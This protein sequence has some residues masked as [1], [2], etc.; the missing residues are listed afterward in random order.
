MLFGCEF[1]YNFVCKDDDVATFG[2]DVGA[3]E[4]VDAA[5]P[6]QNERT[7]RKSAREAK[8]MPVFKMF[9]N[10]NFERLRM[11]YA[12]CHPCNPGRL[13]VWLGQKQHNPSDEDSLRAGC[14]LCENVYGENKKSSGV[15]QQ[16]K[17]MPAKD[18]DLQ[19]HHE[20]KKHQR[21]LRN[22]YHSQLDMVDVSRR[23]LATKDD[24]KPAKGLP[25]CKDIAAVWKAVVLKHS[26]TPSDFARDKAFDEYVESG[27]GAVTPSKETKNKKLGKWK[28]RFQKLLFCMA[29]VVRE[30][31]RRS[32]KN[33]P[34]VKWTMTGDGKVPCECCL[35]RSVNDRLQRKSGLL[36]I[37]SDDFKGLAG[38]DTQKSMKYSLKLASLLHEMVK[39]FCTRGFSS[40]AN[41]VR[42]GTFDA[43]LCAGML[44]TLRFSFWDGAPAVQAAAVAFAGQYCN[45]FAWNERDFAHEVR[46]AMQLS[47]HSEDISKFEQEVITKKNSLVKDIQ[48]GVT[49]TRASYIEAQEA[50]IEKDGCQ[51]GNLTTVISH[52][53]YAPQRWETKTLV[54][55]HWV[56][57]L[58]AWFLTC[59]SQCGKASCKEIKI[60]RA[61]TMKL[62]TRYYY[63]LGGML[64]DYYAVSQVLVKFGDKRWQDPSVLSRHQRRWSSKV[65]G[66]YLKSEVLST[67]DSAKNLY[68]QIVLRQLEQ[69][70]FCISQGQ[71]AAIHVLGGDVPPTNTE[72]LTDALATMSVATSVAIAAV[73]ELLNPDY[74]QTWWECMDLQQWSKIKDDT[75][76]VALDTRNAA[77]EESEKLLRCREKLG[78]QLSWP[79]FE[80][81]FVSLVKKALTIFRSHSKPEAERPDDW[82]WTS[83]ADA[84]VPA[85]LKKS[86]LTVMLEP[87]KDL[88]LACR[89]TTDNERALFQVARSWKL[90]GATVHTESIRDVLTVYLGA[91]QSLDKLVRIVDGVMMPLE[92]AA[93]TIAFWEELF[94]YTYT[95]RKHKGTPRPSKVRTKKD[96]KSLQFRGVQAAFRRHCRKGRGNDSTVV[97]KRIRSLRTSIDAC[98]LKWTAKQCKFIENMKKKREPRYIDQEARAA[99]RNI[100]K[101]KH[102]TRM[103]AQA[104]A[105]AKAKTVKRLRVSEI[106]TAKKVFIPCAIEGF[107]LPPQ[108]TKVDDIAIA[109][110]VVVSN[111]AECT[112]GQ[113][114]ANTDSMPK[115]MVVARVK[116]KRMVSTDYFVGGNAGDLSSC[117]SVKFKYML[118]RLHGFFFDGY[119]GGYQKFVMDCVKER[120]SKWRELDEATFKTWKADKKMK[121]QC[122]RVTSRVDFIRA[123]VGLSCVDHLNSHGRNKYLAL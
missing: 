96:I 63:A 86:T 93:E 24:W 33:D 123:V 9:W 58:I 54:L 103:A 109:Q 78:G 39:R 66:L 15:W 71:S 82:N 85:V 98:R 53:S 34:G 110:L 119:S 35:Y 122:T 60:S 16:F 111:L 106:K 48:Y 3:S 6:V 7:R 41:F 40:R 69:R 59:A 74:R 47:K 108:F 94:G 81:H 90:R 36:D 97:N 107:M 57:T 38:E 112:I 84:Y 26:S 5:E 61:E 67:D 14:H 79:N 19:R 87:I 95:D 121:K 105:Q 55:V 118:S 76:D 29:E 44:D 27:G 42:P 120:G 20:S 45:N 91:P 62:M 65:E 92:F 32:F 11:E 1:G 72:Y 17:S 99:K 46:I 114:P 50:V 115:H 8:K 43:G 89:S 51:G 25:P 101:E 21:A 31:G 70:P 100:Y 22:K 104:K 83:W 88:G 23:H 80:G 117:T 68:T 13:V 28:I 18:Q 75:D 4:V 49:T 113:D 77:K 56:L 116:G 12:D 73:S 30:R 52:M 64:A 102:N 37:M 10:G 2:S